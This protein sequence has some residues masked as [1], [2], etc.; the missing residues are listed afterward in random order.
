MITFS[1]FFNERWM[2]EGIPEQ[3]IG[4]TGY[5]Y[6]VFDHDGTHFIPMLTTPEGEVIIIPDEVDVIPKEILAKYHMEHGALPSEDDPI[7]AQYKDKQIKAMRDRLDQSE[8][9][10]KELDDWFDSGSKGP[11]PIKQEEY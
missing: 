1:K 10:Q 3:N 4:D 11:Y 9:K 6:E 7:V 5:R 8:R 2:S